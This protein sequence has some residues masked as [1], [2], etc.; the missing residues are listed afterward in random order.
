MLPENDREDRKASR[1]T[2]KRS[3]ND[4][5]PLADEIEKEMIDQDIPVETGVRPEASKTA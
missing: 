2:D 3:K 5:G 4:G 1:T